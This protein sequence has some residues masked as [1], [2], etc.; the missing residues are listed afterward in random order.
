MRSW[1]SRH[2]WEESGLP[3]GSI[4]I[5]NIS[6]GET[7]AYSEGYKGLSVILYDGEHIPADD[8][9]YDLLICNSVIEHVIKALLQEYFRSTHLLKR[10]EV[11][12]LLSG[13]K[14]E[15]E[16][17]CKLRKSHLVFWCRPE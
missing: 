12:T 5:L 8:C 11:E 15:R 13:T 3:L 1:G 16:R 2:F 9:E 6:H 7:R 17:F 4:V 10:T 14:V